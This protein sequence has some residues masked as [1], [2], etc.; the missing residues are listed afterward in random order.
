MFHGMNYVMEVYKEQSFSKAAQNLYISQPALSAAIKK[1]EKKVGA[2][3]FDRSV[4]PIQLTECG[5]EYIRTTEKILDLEEEFTYYVGNLHELKSG[6]LSLGGTCFFASFIFPPFIEQFRQKFPHVNLDF[7]EGST[8]ELEQKLF[9]GELDIVIDNYDLNPQIYQRQKCFQE[10]LL[11]AVPASFDSNRRAKTYQ[12]TADDVIKDVHRNPR[13]P[14]VP[15]RKFKDD[16]FVVLRSHNDTRE[17]IDAICQREN[18][19]PNYV[20]KLD[21][22]MTTY[23]LT[24]YGMGISIVN[25]TLIKYL[26]PDSSVIYYKLAA[27]ESQR[28]VYLYYKKNAY[29]TRAMQEFIRIAIP[30]SCIND[31][32]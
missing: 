32:N 1:I 12:L 23:R 14:E 13:F 24:Q 26:H 22:V 28:D 21:Q 15:L 3:L 5:K 6:H 30:D 9:N 10:Q 11:L 19:Q 4:S 8:L 20:L 27:P 29:L 2:P 16:P 31:Q 17:R 25:D 7:Y 18:I